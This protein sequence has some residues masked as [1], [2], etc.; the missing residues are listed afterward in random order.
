MLDDAP[1]RTSFRLIAAIG[2]LCTL[3]A[4]ATPPAAGAQTRVIG[5]RDMQAAVDAFLVPGP[6]GPVRVVLGPC[7]SD[8]SAQGCHSAGATRDTI[9]LSPDAGGLDEETLAH[10]MGHVFESYMWALYWRD[11]DRARFVPDLLER[12]A[13]DL[14]ADPRPGVLY[15]TAWSERF[16]EAYSLCTRVDQIAEPVSSGYWG[17]S[18]TPESHART[19]RLIDELAADYERLSEGDSTAAVSAT[20]SRR[21]AASS[22]ARA[23][24]SAA[25]PARRARI[26]AR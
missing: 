9:W 17:F 2:G 13:S 25:R 22:T 23:G 19:C 1:H 12:I 26:V 5:P 10:E 18:A 3:L 15:S 11:G 7:P 16:A 21:L 4:I 24:L 6:P 14:F 20:G 8:P